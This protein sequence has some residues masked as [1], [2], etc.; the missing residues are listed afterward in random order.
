[1]SLLAGALT[2]ADVVDVPDDGPGLRTAALRFSTAADGL[3]DAATSAS[4]SWT[5]LP[6]VLSADA[7]TSALAPM[8]D[9]AFDR[10]RSIRTA[11]DE[12]HQVASRAAV[13]LEHLH[14]EHDRLVQ[15]IDQFHRSAPGQVAA[16]AAHEAASGNLIGAAVTVVTSWQQVPALVTEEASLRWRVHAHNDDVTS[17][18]SRIAAQVDAVGTADFATVAAVGTASASDEGNWFEDAW[19]HVEGAAETGWA[20]VEAAAEQAWPYV[21]DFGA[22][23]GNVAASMGNAIV[24]HPDEFGALIGGLL[25]M[26]AGSA[27]EGGG[28]ALDI[29]GVGAVVGVPANVAGAAMMAAGAATALGG[30]ASLGVHAMTDDEVTPNDTDHV[31]NWKKEQNEN[32][33]GRNKDGTYRKDG[34]DEARTDAKAKEAQ[35]VKEAADDAGLP[36]RTDQVTARVDGVPNGRVFDGLA[37]K[38]DG[39]YAGI[40]VKSGTASRT[41]PQRLFDDSVSYDHPATATLPDGTVIKITSVILKKVP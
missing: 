24:N 33:P 1:M 34:N 4:R 5:G 23:V 11:A 22:T 6:Q 31:Q 35:G 3:L 15:Q 36:Y 40:E 16:H 37:E 18:L 17:T 32:H 10:A 14:E 30:G 29:T 9:P 20:G 7:V 27:V 28:V 21:Q 25:L 13:E 8:M 2:A 12:F 26:A 41:A 39:T 38:P 19:H